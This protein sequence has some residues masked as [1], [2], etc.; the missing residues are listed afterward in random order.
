M[1]KIK[2][3]QIGAAHL[4]APASYK[5]ILK[6]SDIFDFV[7]F[8]VPEDEQ[9]ES[10]PFYRHK[11]SEITHT[12]DEIFSIPDLDAVAIDVSEK[13][14]SKYALMAVE[15]GL[16]VYMDKPGGSDPEEF[17]K[18]IETVKKSGKVFHLGYMYRY[19]PAFVE[20]LEKVRRGDVG[21]VFSIDAQMS[22]YSSREIREWLGELPGGMMYNLGCHLID[23]ILQ[24][25]GVPEKVVPLNASTGYEGV[26]SKDL[27]LAALIYK[28]GVSTVKTCALERGGFVRRQFVVCGT[29][30]TLEI[31]PIERNATDSHDNSQLCTDV[32]ETYSDAWVTVPEMHT[33][34][35]YDR[36]GEMFSSFAAEIR[37]ERENPYTPDYEL[38][39]Y[40]TLM[41]CCG[42]TEK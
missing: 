42:V 41:K 6:Q 40:R 23:M 20:L 24:I 13:N 36:Y 18:L 15:K 1:K 4:H 21:D 12:V 28:N 7:G 22:C 14:L 25:Q 30:G 2:I 17:E 37:G 29:K 3:A 9:K 38:T 31:R 26:N 5:T 35:V 19:N 39:L 16:H 27:G 33:T 10:V 34:E 8:A 32:Y 11:K